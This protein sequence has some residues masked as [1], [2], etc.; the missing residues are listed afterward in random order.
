MRELESEKAFSREQAAM[1]KEEMRARV[2]EKKAKF[3]EKF[4]R[5]TKSSTNEYRVDN[6]DKLLEDLKMD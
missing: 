3:N 2:Q 6:M 4:S 1:R 5:A